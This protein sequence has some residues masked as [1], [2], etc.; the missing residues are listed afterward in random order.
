M[1]LKKK[2]INLMLIN[3][4]KFCSEKLLKKCLKNLLKSNKKNTILLI[5]IAINSMVYG[6][7]S[8]NLILGKLKNQTLKKLK[9]FFLTNKNKIIFGLK[10]IIQLFKNLNNDGSSFLNNFKL[11][12]SSLLLKKNNINHFKTEEHKIILNAQNMLIFYRY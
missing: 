1:L 5:L 10:L 3:G 6:F 2:I 4:K 12:F 11:K 8:S 7:K 9:P